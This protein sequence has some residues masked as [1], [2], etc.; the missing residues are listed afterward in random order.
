MLCAA[1][2]RNSV[3]RKRRPTGNDR[4]MRIGA[5]WNQ[6][7]H[8][9]VCPP[10][11][12]AALAQFGSY[13]SIEHAGQMTDAD[14]AAAMRAFDVLLIGWSS[15]PIPPSIATDPG[16][17]R[18][19]CSVTGSIRD[20]VPRA[21]I[22]AGIPVTN[23]GDTPAF[24]IAEGAMTLL[25]AVLKE[26][27]S[28][29]ETK[30]AGRWSADRI[31]WQSSLRDLRVG[32]YGLGVIGLRFVELIRPF[33]PALSVFDPFAP[34][35]PDGVT[36]VDSLDALFAA[37]DA[38]VIHAALTDQTRA[39]VDARRLAML[40]DGGILINTARGAIVDQPALFAELAS[41]RLRAGLDVLDDHG[42]DWLAEKD[43]AR[44]WPNLILTAHRV[45]G[46]RWPERNP[47]GRL[48]FG[49]MHSVCL[50]NIHRFAAGQPLL[51][52]FDLDR[53]DRS[54]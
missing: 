13:E 43:P 54:T 2:R 51:F 14:R 24:G 5:F 20:A 40:P 10:A 45:G 32:L 9:G 18:Y 46:S 34:Y 47:D 44:Q 3:S 21:V 11:L 12:A 16:R 25:L 38:I 42:K 15:A 41:G 39:S 22:E 31:E 36:R 17:V 19:I 6:N 53:Y 37:N 35:L 52:A 30:A 27:R 4:I 28:H 48:K 33:Q 23:W 29:I 8:T 49:H 50:D 7:A 26:I 1:M